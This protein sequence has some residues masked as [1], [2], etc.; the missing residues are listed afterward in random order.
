MFKF[1]FCP[2][3]TIMSFIFFVSV[4]D[5]A[6]YILTIIFTFSEGYGFND[7]TFLGPSSHVLY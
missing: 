4:V 3:F 6:L 1:A 2:T 5:V 7:L